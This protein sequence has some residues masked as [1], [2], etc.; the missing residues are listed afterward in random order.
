MKK[1]YINLGTY[2]EGKN[3]IKFMWIEQARR[4]FITFKAKEKRELAAILKNF[5]RAQRI[6]RASAKEKAIIKNHFINKNISYEYI[7]SRNPTCEIKTQEGKQEPRK[8]E[9][10]F[11]WRIP[12]YVTIQSVRR[13]LKG[14]G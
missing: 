8:K 2:G 6:L 12:G 11:N 1:D 3:R 9:Y 13:L 5:R 4:V 7:A 14:K 10:N